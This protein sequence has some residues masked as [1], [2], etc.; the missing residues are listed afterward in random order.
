[1]WDSIQVGVLKLSLFLRS[2]MLLLLFKAEPT[3]VRR[4]EGQDLHSCLINV[5]SSR[6]TEDV[7]EACPDFYSCPQ[8]T[9]SAL[10]APLCCS[11]VRQALK[12]TPT[13]SRFRPPVLYGGS[14]VQFS[15]ACVCVCMRARH[16]SQR[17]TLVRHLAA[18]DSEGKSKLVNVR[19]GV[20][21][22][23]FPWRQLA[24]CAVTGLH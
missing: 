20:F 12:N 13:T 16:M 11:T 21:Q 2:L 24:G 15:R 5:R 23:L 3:S 10:C 6:G 1:M 19:T 9:L 8:R 4:T 17:S 7:C 14:Q 18:G 22:R